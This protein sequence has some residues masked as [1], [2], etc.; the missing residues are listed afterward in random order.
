M[1]QF[2]VIRTSCYTWILA[3]LNAL[4]FIAVGTGVDGDILQLSG[5]PTTDMA[6]PWRFFS[7]MF[8]QEYPLHLIGNMAALIIAGVWFE[9]NGARISII[10]V[11]IITGLAGGIAFVISTALAHGEASLTGCSAAILGIAASAVC[12]RQHPMRHWQAL[13]SI[14]VIVAASGTLGPNPGGSLAHIAGLLAGAI[15]GR[16]FRLSR[17]SKKSYDKNPL[18]SKAELSG[19]ASLNSEERAKLFINTSMSKNQ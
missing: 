15:I 6:Q 16:C 4:L 18:V 12:D 3:L 7:Y 19:Y 8:L 1:N 9:R 2:K 13:L 14:A 11:Y 17:P 10:A 5:N